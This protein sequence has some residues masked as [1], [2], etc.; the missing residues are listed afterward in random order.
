MK[1][2]DTYEH[3]EPHSVGNRRRVLISDLSG[4]ANIAYKAQELGVEIDPKDER[5]V[6]ILNEAQ[7]S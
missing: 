5:I 6:D 3:V 7:G 1:N 4:R 2:S